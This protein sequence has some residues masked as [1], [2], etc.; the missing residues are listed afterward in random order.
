MTIAGRTD[1]ILEASEAGEAAVR[2]AGE[3]LLAGEILK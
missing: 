1:L 2:E 3:A